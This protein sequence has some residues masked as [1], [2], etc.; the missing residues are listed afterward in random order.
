MAHVLGPIVAHKATEPGALD[1]FAV[2]CTCGFKA[3]NTGKVGIVND[4]AAHARW[5][6]GKG[7][8]VHVPL[9]DEDLKGVTL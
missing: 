2:T 3:T 5:H 6:A 1:G 4:A 8:Q 9:G 7:E